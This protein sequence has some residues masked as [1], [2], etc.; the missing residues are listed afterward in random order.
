MTGARRDWVMA[1]CTAKPGAVEAKAKVRVAPPGPARNDMADIMCPWTTR[2][3]GFIRRVVRGASAY[4]ESEPS[5]RGW[6][7]TSARD[8]HGSRP[9]ARPGSVAAHVNGNEVRDAWFCPS[10]RLEVAGYDARAAGDLVRRV[11]AELDAG[12]PAGPGKTTPSVR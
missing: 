7:H 4:R 1:A 11:A 3:Q 9:V 12:R 8:R 10:Q 2:S 6:C 5:R